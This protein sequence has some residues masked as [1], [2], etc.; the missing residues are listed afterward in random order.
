[1][2]PEGFR[3]EER[4]TWSQPWGGGDFLR[5]LLLED[6][7]YRCRLGKTSRL[8]PGGAGVGGGLAPQ[9]GRFSSVWIAFFSCVLGSWASQT[10]LRTG[11]YYSSVCFL[12]LK[13]VYR[14]I[15]VEDRKLLRS[16]SVMF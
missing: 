15:T 2:V 9:G 13:T 4:V 7:D 11:F 5:V 1:M 14:G 6:K 10:T 8:L 3:A 12:S 16:L